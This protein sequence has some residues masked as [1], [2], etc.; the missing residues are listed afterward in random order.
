MLNCLTALL[1]LS[2]PSGNV[3]LELHGYHPPKTLTSLKLAKNISCLSVPIH[4]IIVRFSVTLQ[5]IPP[6]HN[7]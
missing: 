1:M 2:L 3:L 5:V 4:G 6:L 7:P